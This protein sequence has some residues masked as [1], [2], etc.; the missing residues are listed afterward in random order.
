MRGR[1]RTEVGRNDCDVIVI[2]FP[3]HFHHIIE[4]LRFRQSSVGNIFLSAG[5]S[6]LAG[7]G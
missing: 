3:A 1:P 2:F 6:W 7:L 5:E 4:Q